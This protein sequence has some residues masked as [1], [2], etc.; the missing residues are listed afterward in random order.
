MKAVRA[1]MFSLMPSSMKSY[2]E[3][4]VTLRNEVELRMKT[5]SWYD[6]ARGRRKFRV[7]E[8]EDGRLI[9]PQEVIK[10]EATVS[11]EVVEETDDTLHARGSVRRHSFVGHVN[12][13]KE[14]FEAT[15]DTKERRESRSADRE[16]RGRTFSSTVSARIQETTKALQGSGSAK[17]EANSGSGF[18]SS[19]ATRIQEIKTSVKEEASSRKEQILTHKNR[20]LRDINENTSSLKAAWNRNIRGT[21]RVNNNQQ[22]LLDEVKIFAP[23][24]LTLPPRNVFCV[25]EFSYEAQQMDELCLTR[26]DILRPLFMMEAGWW[27]GQMVLPVHEEKKNIVGIFPANYVK[28]IQMRENSSE[29]AKG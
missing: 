11:I 10:E 3:S 5:M 28:C 17:E 29:D 16:Q 26:G 14:R 12:R 1:K 20:L 19:V 21:L 23:N 27:A 25:A 24:S 22:K 6:R 15:A 18:S 9:Q 2:G 7:N 8:E 13:M 4:A